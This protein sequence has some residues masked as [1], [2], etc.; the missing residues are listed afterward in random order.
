[1]QV[2]GPHQDCVIAFA[3]RFR[4][5]WSLIIVP[6]FTTRLFAA[7]GRLTSVNLGEETSVVLPKEAPKQWYPT[8]YDQTEQSLESSDNTLPLGEV[9]RSFPVAL[10]SNAHKTPHEKN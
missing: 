1:M 9:F 3:R 8:F 4:G 2:R 5:D 10:L 6:R 7:N